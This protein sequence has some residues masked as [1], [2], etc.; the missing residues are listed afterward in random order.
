MGA[1][2]APHRE[3]SG[4]YRRAHISYPA[5]NVVMRE[6]FFGVL[7]TRCNRR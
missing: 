4:S 5:A 6:R 2:I 1:R 3:A 7:L